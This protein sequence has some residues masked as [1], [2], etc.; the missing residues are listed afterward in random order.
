MPIYQYRC[1]RCF[2]KFELRQSFDDDA[3]IACPQCGSDARRIFSP[4]PI[5][6]KGSG[7]YITDSRKSEPSGKASKRKSETPEKEK[8]KDDKATVGTVEKDGESKG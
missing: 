6:F 7:F 2:H 1:A 3:E 4:V 5:I 8:S